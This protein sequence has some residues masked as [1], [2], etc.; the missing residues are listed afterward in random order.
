MFFCCLD[1]ENKEETEIVEEK[2]TEDDLKME[3][4]GETEEYLDSLLSD[5]D[6]EDSDLA[7]EIPSDIC[8]LWKIVLS[9]QNSTEILWNTRKDYCHQLKYQ[10][11]NI[12]YKYISITEPKILTPL[13]L[14]GKS[15]SIFSLNS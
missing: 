4:K 7:E 1:K 12:K 9:L 14:L 5:L 13:H 15:M 6:E 2:N 10:I 11:W 8:K 3:K